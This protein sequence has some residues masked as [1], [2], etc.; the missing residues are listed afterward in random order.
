LNYLEIIE[1]H[2]NY[3]DLEILFE[4]V[5]CGKMAEAKSALNNFF[6]T[7]KEVFIENRVYELEQEEQQEREND[8][9][10]ER[11]FLEKG[12]PEWC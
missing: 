1:Y 10:M 5:Q 6:G 4:F 9:Y 3:T 12:Y 7:V 11:Y 2:D 8:E